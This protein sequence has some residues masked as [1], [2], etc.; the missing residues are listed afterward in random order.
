MIFR[1]GRG[2]TSPVWDEFAGPELAGRN[3]DGERQCQCNTCK[4]FILYKGN[5]TNMIVHLRNHHREIYDQIEPS[6][7]KVP[8]NKKRKK[9]GASGGLFDE[10]KSDQEEANCGSN[11]DD[12][13]L[14]DSRN[15]VR[16]FSSMSGSSGQSTS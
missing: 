5:T 8:A 10:E 12:D 14:I 1:M 4:D 11:L 2:R 3:N 13:E 6:L 9:S 15:E 7:R 16:S